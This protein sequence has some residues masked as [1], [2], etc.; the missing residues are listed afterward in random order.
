M[1]TDSGY[2]LC[3]DDFMLLVMAMSCAMMI[4]AITY[5]AYELCFDDLH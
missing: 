4:M 2:E 5:C 3:Y 1:L